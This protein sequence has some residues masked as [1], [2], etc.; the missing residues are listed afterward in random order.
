MSREVFSIRIRKE[1]K[2]IVKKYRDVD[3]RKLIEELIEEVAARKEIEESFKELDQIFKN[4]P[5]SPE[6]GWITVRKARET[7]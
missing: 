3:W 4:I 2:E 1:L 6:P 7:R 5:P